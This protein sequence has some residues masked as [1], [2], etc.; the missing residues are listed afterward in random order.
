MCDHLAHLTKGTVGELTSECER[1]RLLVGL[2]REE[3]QEQ[4]FRLAHRPRFHFVT[5]VTAG[6]AAVTATLNMLSHVVSGVSRILIPSALLILNK[7]MH[8]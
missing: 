1:L 2:R 3:R 7:R 4:S 8:A 5:M 6:G